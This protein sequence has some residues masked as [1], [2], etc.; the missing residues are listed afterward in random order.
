MFP[1]EPF[2]LKRAPYGP[3]LSRGRQVV[4]TAAFLVAMVGTLALLWWAHTL[5]PLVLAGGGVGVMLLLTAVGWLSTP[6]SNPA[7]VA[8]AG[9]RTG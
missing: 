1:P 5:A 2:D 7:P 9:L 6:P 8:P 3:A 4:A